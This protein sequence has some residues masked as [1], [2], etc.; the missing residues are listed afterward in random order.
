MDI[1]SIVPK[2]ETTAVPPAA[3]NGWYPIPSEE[4]TLTRIPP[5]GRV[6]TFKS[7]VTDEAVPVNVIEEI[8]LKSS[9]KS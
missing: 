2:P 3:T 1:D 8:P 6:P 5:L 9:L 4:P 7:D